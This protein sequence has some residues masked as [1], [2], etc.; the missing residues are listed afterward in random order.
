MTYRSVFAALCWLECTRARDLRRSKLHRTASSLLLLKVR[1]CCSSCIIVL[2]AVSYFSLHSKA[3]FEDNVSSSCASICI[4]SATAFSWFTWSASIVTSC[5]NF[6]LAGQRPASH[7][8]SLSCSQVQLL[9]L[10]RKA[11]CSQGNSCI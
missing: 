9:S 11:V 6:M 10:R 5:C 3:C 8:M 7:K 1:I 2:L 4:F